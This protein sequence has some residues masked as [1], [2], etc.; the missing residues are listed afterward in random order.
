[1]HSSSTEIGTQNHSW[2]LAASTIC[3]TESFYGNFFMKNVPGP[4]KTSNF[5]CF[6][7]TVQ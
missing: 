6:L 4:L 5:W 2:L 3:L 1:M 7:Y